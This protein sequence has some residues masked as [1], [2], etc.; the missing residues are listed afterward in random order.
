MCQLTSG[1][2]N[3]RHMSTPSSFRATLTDT[4]RVT[5]V[6]HLKEIKMVEPLFKI[7]C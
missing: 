1:N 2:M 6:T 4:R 3:Q 7:F 5:Q